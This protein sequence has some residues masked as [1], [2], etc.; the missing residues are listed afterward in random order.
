MEGICVLFS[1]FG[2]QRFFGFM[3]DRAS[4][5]FVLRRF[6]DF[7]VRIAK[8]YSRAVTSLTQLSSL[9]AGRGLGKYMYRL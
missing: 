1:L 2:I 6:C 9:L 4:E 8:K 5:G 3:A 7:G